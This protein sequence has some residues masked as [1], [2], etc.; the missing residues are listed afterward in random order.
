MAKRGG[1]KLVIKGGGASKEKGG[2]KVGG[3]KRAGKGFGGKT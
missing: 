2:L 3:R 1:S